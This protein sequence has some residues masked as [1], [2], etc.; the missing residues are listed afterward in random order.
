MIFLI[1]FSGLL[2]LTKKKVWREVEKPAEAATA[3][4]RQTLTN[5][6]L[7]ARRPDRSAHSL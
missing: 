7:D 1:V 6:G 5:A 2:Y 3:H 4:G